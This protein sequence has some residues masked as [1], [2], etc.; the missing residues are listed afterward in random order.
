MQPLNAHTEK[1]NAHGQERKEESDEWIKGC[2]AP[3]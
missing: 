3:E 1:E 2:E